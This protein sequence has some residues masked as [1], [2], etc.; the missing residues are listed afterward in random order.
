MARVGPFEPKRGRI[1]FRLAEREA[2]VLRQLLGTLEMALASGETGGDLRRLFPP[3][4][5]DDEDAQQEFSSLV[6]DDLRDA[7]RVAIVRCIESLDM[8]K[9]RSSMVIGELDEE[10]QS[11]WLHVLNDL[12]LMLGTRLGVTEEAYDAFDQEP[13]PEDPRAAAI[14]LYLYLGWLQECL[15]EILLA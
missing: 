7:K 3:A 15:V 6:T 8:A 2:D 14:H 4:Y 5:P 1:G 9:H 11:A 13:D 10:R 12:R